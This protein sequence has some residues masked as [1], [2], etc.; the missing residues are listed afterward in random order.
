MPAYNDSEWFALFFI[1]YIIIN[2]Y[3]FMNLFLAVIYNSYRT[4]LKVLLKLLLIKA[5][6]K[7][8]G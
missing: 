5:T 7:T 1:V 8:G 2:T 6:Q 4:H 3:I